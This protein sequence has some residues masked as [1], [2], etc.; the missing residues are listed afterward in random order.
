MVLSGC[1][2]SGSESAASPSTD[3]I[4]DPAVTASVTASV[5]CAALRSLDNDLV[6]AVNASVA[7]INTLP[8]DERMAAI[9]DGADSIGEIL[10]DWRSTVDELDLADD[11]HSDEL[12]GQLRVGADE[13]VAELV[14]QRQT[15]EDQPELVVDREVQGVVGTWFN[16]IEKVMSVIEPEI[17]GFDDAA[18]EQAFQDEPACRHVIQRYVVD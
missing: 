10:D 11:A 14:R 6:H 17:A 5:T 15:F 18:F 13:A 2:T 3:V 12:R 4:A 16:S 7:S 9:L 8:A 1:G